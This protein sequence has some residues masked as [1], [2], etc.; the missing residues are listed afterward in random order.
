[1]SARFVF[2]ETWEVAAPPS[3]VHRVLVDLERYPVWWPQVVAVASLGPDHARALCRSALPYTL[4]LVLAAVDRSPERLAVELGGDLDGSV[5]FDLSPVA[6]GTRLD[7][8]QEVRAGGWLGVAAY[9][10]RPVLRW[11]HDQMMRG[12]LA[13]L[14]R[15]A[16]IEDMSP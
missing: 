6:G 4:D 8:A 2:Q 1:M 14:R 3:A 9:V 11:N 7:F 13:G 12:C 16:S 5:T 15:Q 10:G